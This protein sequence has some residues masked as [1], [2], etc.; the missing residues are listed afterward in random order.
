MRV[1][2][3]T[4]ADINK[5]TPTPVNTQGYITTV[6]VTPDCLLSYTDGALDLT[7]MDGRVIRFVGLTAAHAESLLSD[8]E[9]LVYGEGD[10]G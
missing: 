1:K 2:T 6:N 9:Y 7:M 3:K 5:I 4:L 10:G 8:L